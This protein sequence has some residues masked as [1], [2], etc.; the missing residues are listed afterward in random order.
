MKHRPYCDA[1]RR[2]CLSIFD[3]NC[4]TFFAPN[5]R[6]EYLA[7]LEDVPAGYEVCELDGRV[8]G[9]YGLT[10]HAES[11]SSL[12]WIMLDPGSQGIGIGTTVM[13]RAIALAKASRSPLINIAASQ[14]SAPFFARF[15]A[16]A[17][18]RIKDGWGP[19]MDRL[20][21]ELHL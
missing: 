12:N 5:E 9:A 21:M 19:G 8:V 1:D 6:A 2:A 10:H 20:D 14:K 7:F 17:T 3:A 15:G 16:V 4:P 11:G 13:S 18:A